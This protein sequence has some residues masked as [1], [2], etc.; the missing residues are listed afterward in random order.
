MIVF[1]DIFFFIGMLIFLIGGGKLLLDNI[2]TILLVIIIIIVFFVLL[3]KWPRAVFAGLV[4]GV[5]ALSIC[6]IIQNR[7]QE[8]NIPVTIYIAIDD[9][10]VYD[11]DENLI[12]IPNGAI[13][14]RYQDQRERQ[15]EGTNIYGFKNVCH[16]YHNGQLHQFLVSNSHETS[17][18]HLTLSEWNVSKLKQITYKEFRKGN[19][20]NIK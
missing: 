11:K 16:W 14:A 19:W 5:L 7:S 9:C 15:P 18:S 3:S 17:F 12:T 2:F 13:I 10:K 8:N 4:I 20:I 6:G 1:V